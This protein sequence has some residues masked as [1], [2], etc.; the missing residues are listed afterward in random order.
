MKNLEFLR[1]CDECVTVDEQNFVEDVALGKIVL[2]LN[3]DVIKRIRKSNITR[4]QLTIN[5][6]VLK[7]LAIEEFV[8]KFTGTQVLYNNL[9]NALVLKKV[10]LKELLA[11]N[12]E[13]AEYSG[14]TLL[15]LLGLR[16]DQPILTT[17]P[18]SAKHYSNLVRV[19]QDS[20]V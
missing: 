12:A 5:K 2:R 3:A 9:I 18:L 1:W 15:Q 19:L 10:S 8:L 17:S 7:K 16:T 20:L 4:P 11:F 6:V 14:N 13:Y